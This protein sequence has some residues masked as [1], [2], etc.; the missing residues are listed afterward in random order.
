MNENRISE[1]IDLLN[2]ASGC[3]ENELVWLRIE[4][5]IRRDILTE[6]TVSTGVKSEEERED[7]VQKSVRLLSLYEQLTTGK[8]V[9]KKEAARTFRV[10]D[11]TIQ[12]DLDDIRAYL[13][14]ARD[15]REL[16]YDRRVKGYVIV[17][18]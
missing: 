15:G 7:M 18:R 4:T 2:E 1:L 13:A 14:E 17:T 10:I 9:Y 12:R 3:L 16:I 8:V 5:I 11:K 6:N